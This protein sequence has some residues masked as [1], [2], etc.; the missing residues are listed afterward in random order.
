MT[1]YSV[2]AIRLSLVHLLV[3]FSL[4]ALMLIAKGPG[5][6]AWSMRY[7]PV[8]M[9]VLLMGWFLN[10]IFGVAYW[11]FPRFT[12]A[13]TGLPTRGYQRAAWLALVLL[14]AGIGL[15]VLG[16]TLHPSVGVRLAGRLLE[17]AAVLAFLVNLW[18]RVK[19]VGG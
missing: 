3:G 4:G 15:F 18:P 1:A 17:A 16:H 7:L 5:W 12:P 9:E 13:K 8:H 10:L 11:M 19:P 2:W 14:N 6:F